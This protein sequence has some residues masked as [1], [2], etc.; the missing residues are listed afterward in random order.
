MSTPRPSSYMLTWTLIGVVTL[1]ISL[2]I[3]LTH[4]TRWMEWHLSRLGE[5]ESLA[6][7]IFNFT[8]VMAAVILAALAAR[9]MSEVST[10]G[11]HTL[12][13]LLFGVAICWIG[14]GCFPFDHFPIIHNIFGYSQFL[15]MGYLLLR[16][17]TICPCFSE[18][19]YTIGFGVVIITSILLALFHLTHFTTL[20]IVEII[21]QLGIYMW[22]LSMAADLRKIAMHHK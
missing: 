6:A 1:G 15:L 9:I 7:A 2:S 3:A 16:L 18:H 14:I 19:T 13:S 5:G 20:L 11:V 12:R 21:G 8:F 22:L 17:R 10:P 4:D